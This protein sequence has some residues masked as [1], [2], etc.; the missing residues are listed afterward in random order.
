MISHF[1]SILLLGNLVLDTC[2]WAR[3]RERKHDRY[4]RCLRT[5]KCTDQYLR[6]NLSL[7]EFLLA[8]MPGVQE[9]PPRSDHPD[10]GPIKRR[11]AVWCL[12]ARGANL[13]E[14]ADKEED[15]RP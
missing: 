5:M 8:S 2:K 3:A 12:L 13:Q 10:H 6:S 15:C 11:S 4:I 7:D 14:A 9:L 1:L